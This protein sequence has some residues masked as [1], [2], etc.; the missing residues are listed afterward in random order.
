M[1]SCNS[2]EWNRYYVTLVT[3]NEEA[4]SYKE[5]DKYPT[6]IECDD[7]VMIR[8]T[9]VKD[10]KLNF[11]ELSLHCGEV[12]KTLFA[13]VYASRLSEVDVEWISSDEDVAVVEDKGE[14]AYV[15]AKNPGTTYITAKVREGDMVFQAQ[16]EVTVEN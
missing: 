2:F 7:L 13:R 4:E 1:I 11:N 5:L 9:E 10:F 8:T 15:Y 3:Y 16:C 14:I 12:Y 6:Y